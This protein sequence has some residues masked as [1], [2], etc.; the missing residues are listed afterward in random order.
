MKT[1]EG[2]R[3][4]KLKGSLGLLLTPREGKRKVRKGEFSEIRPKPIGWPRRKE[5]K[6]NKKKVEKKRKKKRKKRRKRKEE[7]KKK[8]E[9][10]KKKKKR[11]KRKDSQERDSKFIMVNLTAKT[12]PK[13][14]IAKG[15][16]RY[17]FSVP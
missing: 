9:K 14:L 11:K 7:E 5:R 2:T 10:K 8:K 3:S 13:K 1:K 15:K 6:K 12:K 4:K 17:H 16:L